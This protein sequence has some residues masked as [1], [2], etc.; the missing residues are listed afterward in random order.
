MDPGSEHVARRGPPTVQAHGPR[1][2]RREFVRS[3]GIAAVGV[4]APFSFVRTVSARADRL[5]RDLKQK[6][7]DCNT[8][9]IAVAV[10]RGDEVVFADGVGWRTGSMGS[11]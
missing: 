5:H 7:A 8:P 9:G 11:R 3:A 6:L 10:V 4:V 2:S 1:V